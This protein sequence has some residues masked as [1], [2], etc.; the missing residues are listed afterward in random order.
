MSLAERVAVQRDTAMTQTQDAMRLVHAMR[1]T[2]DRIATIAGGAD[3]NDPKDAD[4]AFGEIL[5][6]A[7][8]AT[9][10]QRTTA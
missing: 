1:E 7:N 9:A 4:R 8:A 2:L 5:R 6:A 3:H 10:S